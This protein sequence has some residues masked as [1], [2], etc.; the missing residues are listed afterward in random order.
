MIP[1]SPPPVSAAVSTSSWFR[2]D[3]SRRRRGVRRSINN[4]PYKSGLFDDPSPC[5]TTLFVVIVIL[6]SSSAPSPSLT[7]EIVHGCLQ[8]PS[9]AFTLT[10]GAYPT[11]LETD[12]SSSSPPRTTT[13]GI[14]RDRGV[15]PSLAYA[16]PRRKS[17]R[18]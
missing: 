16:L 10:H 5:Q 4:L 8:L 14:A 3:A 1:R 13:V 6:K 7:I 17:R 12:P 11:P 15:M 18:L 2:F 9:S